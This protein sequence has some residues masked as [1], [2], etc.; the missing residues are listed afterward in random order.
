ML[1]ISGSVAADVQQILVKIVLG[2]LFADH[3][4][5]AGGPEADIGINVLIKAQLAAVETVV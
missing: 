4:R 1:S 2:A 5:R 3:G